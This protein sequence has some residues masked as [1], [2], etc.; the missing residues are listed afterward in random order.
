MTPFD[1]S[2]DLET[3]DIPA[4]IVFCSPINFN[5]PDLPGNSTLTFG[6]QKDTPPSASEGPLQ[7]ISSTKI[8]KILDVGLE[9]VIQNMALSVS[10]FFRDNSNETL[11]GTTTVSES[12]VVVS[13][14]WLVLPATLLA[15]GA[16]LLVSTFSV[17]KHHK[18]NPWK[19]SSLPVL[20]HGLDDN[21][22]PANREYGSA[23]Q[24]EQI[25]GE[26][27]VRLGPSGIQSRLVFRQ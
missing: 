10:K 9:K 24:M 16:V 25:A 23:S 27:H 22:I 2:G 26:T 20:Y 17:D 21:L 6:I 19:S 3:Q 1:P 4:G 13:W 5:L 12:Y 7:S 14:P 8:Q 18:L 15:L 11:Q